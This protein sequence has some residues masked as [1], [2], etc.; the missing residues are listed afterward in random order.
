MKDF[1]VLQDKLEIK[2]NNRELLI[3]ALCHRSY[4][5]ENTNFRMGHNERLEFLGDAVLELVVTEHLY[6]K[7]PKKNEGDLTTWRA[8]LV[9]TKTLSELSKEI[10]IEDFILLSR[11]EGKAMGRTKQ[12]ILADTLEALIG[13]IYLDSG[14][15]LCKNFIEKNLISKLPR[16]LKLGLH[17]DSK[18]RFQEEAQSR[19]KITPSYKVINELGPDHEKT[20][21]VGIYIGDRLITE[22][23][24]LSKQEAEEEAARRGLEIMK[25]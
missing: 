17:I 2:F 10:G 25:W 24:G 5:N 11:G 22:G 13:A 14:Y 8:A 9:N 15:L 23:D 6:N 3:Q 7:Y 21:T 20:F 1:S 18:S 12:S 4:I 19:E 16:I